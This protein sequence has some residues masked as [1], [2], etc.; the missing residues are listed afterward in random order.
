MSNNTWWAYVQ[1]LIGDDTNSVAADRAGFDK[2]A[3]TRWSKGAGAAP[4]FAVKLARAY[5]ASP[6]PALVASGLL[7]EDE[8]D[9]REVVIGARDALRQ[10]TDA[11]LLRELL[12]RVGGD[13]ALGR[14][15][16]AA[17]RA[18]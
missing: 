10:A 5:G 1:A 4:E 8:A 6:L 16:A 17:G 2:S 18:G 12:H 14:P 13:G 15:G 9:T 11:D 7:T 3:F